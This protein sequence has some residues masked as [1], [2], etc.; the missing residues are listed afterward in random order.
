VNVLLTGGLGYIGSHTAVALSKA[1]Y[2]LV[3]YDDLSNSKISV[4]KAIEQ[5]GGKK[6]NFI[7]GDVLDT[8]KLTKCLRDFGVVSVIHFAGLKAVGESI[9][10]PIR[11]YDSNVG[12]AISLLSAMKS[13]NINHLIFSSSAT[14]Y[15]ASEF[16]AITE[17]HPTKALNPYGRTKLIIEDM[18]NDLAVS[19]PDWR[20]SC[21]RYFNPVG[22][23]ASA[24]LG[25]DPRDI[26]NN[27]MP[28]IVRV[29]AG[30][31]KQL[32]IFGSDYCTDD[33]TCERDYIHVE[34]LA[35][36]HLA[37]LEHIKRQKTPIEF[38]NLG[39]GQS[40]SVLRLV[41]IF[42][43]V[44]GKEVPTV[45]AAR[46]LGDTA[47]CY[48]DVTKSRETLRWEAKKSLNEMCLSSWEYHNSH[49]NDV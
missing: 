30:L 11:Y 32:F 45:T 33:G 38:F 47:V 13:A 23:H 48:A 34:D 10:S 31:D 27:L 44:T 24:S 46:R 15:G 19:D 17:D 25:E 1:D 16:V 49:R 8:R 5:L 43:D 22:A 14:V 37:A 20:I 21:L 35:E 40:C 28:R 18:L 41:A 2:D 3:I 42:K 4:L 9:E 36:G 7:E 26:P 6:V 12:G 29:A 39:T